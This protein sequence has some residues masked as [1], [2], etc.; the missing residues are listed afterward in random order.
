MLELQLQFSDR[1]RLLKSPGTP[2]GSLTGNINAPDSS[3][4]VLPALATWKAHDSLP[5]RLPN[6]DDSGAAW[7]GSKDLT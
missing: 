2:S 4:L 1:R 3:K 5:E 6:Y 7:V